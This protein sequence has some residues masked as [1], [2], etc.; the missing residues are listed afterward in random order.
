MFPVARHMNHVYTTKCVH[1]LILGLCRDWGSKVDRAEEG[2][3]V[4][5][6]RCPDNKCQLPNEKNLK[7]TKSFG[8]LRTDSA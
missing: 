5:F 1:E 7:L 8:K 2:V 3:Q 4:G 6:V